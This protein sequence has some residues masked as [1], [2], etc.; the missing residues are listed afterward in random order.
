MR[1]QDLGVD[2]EH[3][4]VVQGPGIRDNDYF[5]RLTAFKEEILRN[6]MIKS[7]SGSTSIPG[8]KVYW[9]AGGIRR[10]NED[11]SKSNQYRIIG[12]DYDFADAFQL[13]IIAGRNSRSRP[14]L[15]GWHSGCQD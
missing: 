8:S 14:A 6:P 3:T 15:T 4:L 12:I 11:A 5:S 13:S 7:V 10:T 1:N 9:N 2:I